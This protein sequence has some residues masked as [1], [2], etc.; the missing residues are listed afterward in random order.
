ME[1]D[2]QDQSGD[3]LATR[4]GRRGASY[5]LALDAGQ[6][7]G[8]AAVGQLATV[9][10]PIGCTRAEVLAVA[11]QTATL[12]VRR[13]LDQPAAPGRAELVVAAASLALT[14]ATTGRAVIELPPDSGSVDA[15]LSGMGAVAT[16]V[17]A[18][19]TFWRES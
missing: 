3:R 16:E 17:N 5:Q 2:H 15:A 8:G 10:V 19:I 9:R 1:L 11:N 12:T 14:A 13:R 4:F 18:I 7:A 6:D